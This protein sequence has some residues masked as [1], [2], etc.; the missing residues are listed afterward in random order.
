MRAANL[1]LAK[2]FDRTRVSANFETI[3]EQLRRRPPQPSYPRLP[4]G[5]PPKGMRD[6]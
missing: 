1:T 6:E 2:Q 3:Y 4:P 5:D